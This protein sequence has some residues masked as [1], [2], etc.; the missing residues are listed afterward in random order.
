MAYR[1]QDNSTKSED[2]RQPSKKER[3]LISSISQRLVTGL[4]DDALAAITDLLRAGVHP[5]AVVAAVTSLQQQ[6]PRR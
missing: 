3:E 5:D 4:N 6:T 1:L 2:S